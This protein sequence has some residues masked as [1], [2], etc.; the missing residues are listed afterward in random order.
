[1]RLHVSH[2][3]RFLFIS[4]RIL[5]SF[6]KHSCQ[7]C[8]SQALIYKEPMNGRKW[9]IGK[10]LHF[11]T[12][13]LL[14]HPSGNQQLSSLLTS[15]VAGRG[16]EVWELRWTARRM[17]FSFGPRIRLSRQKYG[18]FSFQHWVSQ[19]RS[20]SRPCNSEMRISIQYTAQP[21]RQ[22]RSISGREKELRK[23]PSVSG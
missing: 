6:S 22:S 3:I 10:L 5:P 9:E 18:L 14:V 21:C 19:P 8:L 17:V 13:Q 1:M 23:V 15:T 20:S 7:L 12:N 11:L 4:L 2:S 16:W